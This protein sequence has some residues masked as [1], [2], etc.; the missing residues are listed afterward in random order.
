MAYYADIS[1]ETHVQDNASYVNG[2]GNHECVTFVQSSAAAPNTGLWRAGTKV[3][4][5]KPGTLLK[6]T[7]IATFEGGKYPV[8]NRHAAIYITHDA[9]GIWVYD[10]WNSQGMVK[11]RYIRKK[12]IIDISVNNASRY[13]VIQ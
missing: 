8:T 2:N 11:K 10:Q 9:N 3:L 5:A 4:D 13:Y 6:G 12:P 1:N 7:A